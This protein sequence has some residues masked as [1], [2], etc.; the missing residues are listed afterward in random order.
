VSRA[1][2]WVSRSTSCGLDA[3]VWRRQTPPAMLGVPLVRL[4]S[5]AVPG[6]HHPTTP[7]PQPVDRLTHG[8]DR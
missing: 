6:I 8:Y 3:V 4:R 7:D 1:K 5:R 2:L